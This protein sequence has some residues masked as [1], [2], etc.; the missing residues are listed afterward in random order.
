MLFPSQH[1][2][3]SIGNSPETKTSHASR[4]KYLGKILGNRWSECV[5]N[6]K[7]CHFLTSVSPKFSRVSS[8]NIGSCAVSGA[9]NPV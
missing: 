4:G 6:A 2:D 5:T 3:V 9:S 7:I 1:V 8:G